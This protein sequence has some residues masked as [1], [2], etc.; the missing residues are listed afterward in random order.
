MEKKGRISVNTENIFPIIKRSLYS[1]H[2]IFLRELVSNAVDATLKMKTLSS[3]GEFK[4][5]LGETAVNVAFDKD[6]K[7]ITITD[8]GIGLTADDI[9]KYINQVAF[10]GAAEFMENYKGKTEDNQLIGKFG[11]G[12]YSAFMVADRVDIDSLSYKE[13]AEAASWTC[14]GSTE[15]EI[16]I[17]TRTTRGTTITLHV[18]E[19]STEFLEEHRLKGVLDKYCKFLPIEIVFGTETY[20]EGEGDEKIEKTRDRVINNTK[21]LWTKK[22]ADLNDEDYIA[23]YDELYPFQEKPLFWIHLNV[24][25]PF[26]LTGILYFP[27][28]KDQGYEV[29]KSKIQLFSNQ[30]YITDDVKDVVPEFLRLLHGIIDSPDIP[31][32][33]SRSFLQSDS[34]VKKISNHITKKVADKLDEMF[35]KSREQFEEK[36][37]ELDLFVKYGMLTDEKFYDKAAKFFLFK[38]IESAKFTIEEYKE[39]IAP[40]QTDKDGN[41]VML[42][43]SQ[44]QEQ[45][46]YVEAA[47]KR[48]YDVLDLGSVIDAHF[49]SLMESKLEK[50]NFKR[51]DADTLDKLI[52][53]DTQRESILTEDQSKKVS[54]VLEQVIND[55]TFTV[56]AQ[57]LS[58]DEAPILI[59]RSEWM[60]RMKEQALSGGGGMFGMGNLP[61]QHQVVLNTSHPYVLKMVNAGDDEKSKQLARQAFDLALLSQGMLKGADLNQFIARSIA[62]I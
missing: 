42:Y 43:T 3:L 8:N 23:F 17:G 37:T 13:N 10:S 48:G 14:D 41:L 62:L 45:T 47:K 26:N 25:H 9:E 61:E 28:I 53:Q 32:N 60:R 33:V 7:T 2:E 56:A 4:G 46:T 55:K 38:N 21:P 18:A 12:F 49:V 40:N 36:W 58:P 31:L 35:K 11:L 24:D 50:V 15:F 51:V 59:T 6:K 30:V 27:K 5:E 29:S 20:S 22:P 1:D 57:A 16:G 34:N 54:E 44:A 19:D 39:K 52:A